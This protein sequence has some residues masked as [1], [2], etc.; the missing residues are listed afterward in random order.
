MSSDVYVIKHR[1]ATPPPCSA[2]VHGVDPVPAVRLG[3]F[4]AV[5]LMVQFPK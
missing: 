5:G 4:S 1:Q 2:A 3:Q